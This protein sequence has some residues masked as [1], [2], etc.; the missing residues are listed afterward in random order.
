MPLRNQRFR[1]EI[2]MRKQGSRKRGLKTSH[3]KRFSAEIVNAGR[4]PNKELLSGYNRRAA[5]MSV[6]HMEVAQ[7]LSEARPNEPRLDALDLAESMKVEY[8]WQGP[9][10]Q[11][12]EHLNSRTVKSGPFQKIKF[13]FAGD[14]Y[15]FLKF[16]YINKVVVRSDIYHSMDMA[17]MAFRRESIRWIP[18]SQVPISQEM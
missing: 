11:G 16:D 8:R 14:T 9:R 1:Q 7:E 2:E 18:S 6:S 12:I 13:Y 4:T 5:S 3:L 15:V 10:Y 17:M